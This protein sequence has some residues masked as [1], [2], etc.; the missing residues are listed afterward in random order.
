[1][2]INKTKSLPSA[3]SVSGF[4]EQQDAVLALEFTS[5]LFNSM[6]SLKAWVDKT[7]YNLLLLATTL[8]KQLSPYDAGV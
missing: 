7:L 4:I 3:S 6:G 2:K 1:M 5:S 8:Q